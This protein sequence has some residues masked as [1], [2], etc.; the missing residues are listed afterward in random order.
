MTATLNILDDHFAVSV[1]GEIVHEFRD[2][3]AAALCARALQ[4]EE[5]YNNA[6]TVSPTGGSKRRRKKVA[7]IVRNLMSRAL[8]RAL[9]PVAH[10]KRAIKA[11]NATAKV[12][13]LLPEDRVAIEA[14]KA[15]Y[16][17]NTDR[18]KLS[19]IGLQY[20][21]E[22]STTEVAVWDED[23][24]PVVAF[25]GS[26]NA[27][28]AHTDAHLAVGRIESTARWKRNL[29]QVKKIAEHYGFTEKKGNVLFSGHSLGGTIA[30][31]MAGRYKDSYAV[32]L[33]P[34]AGVGFYPKSRAHI[35]SVRGDVVSALAPI[36]KRKDHKL[37]LLNHKGSSDL[38]SV[39][40]TD[41]F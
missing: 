32:A 33:N 28:D 15:A 20:M 3:K 14:A 35:Y 34:G 21:P 38:L 17:S 41:Q 39:H 8:S 30:L 9:P 27:D 36:A 25:R 22:L 23:G 18:E 6:C 11:L 29:E 31:H 26:A 16:K 2:Y 1:D 7:G 5:D 13:K 37:T 4:I 10:T 40:G 19:K 12:G 24:L